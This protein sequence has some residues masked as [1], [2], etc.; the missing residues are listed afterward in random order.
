MIIDRRLKD[1]DGNLPQCHLVHH[2]S[3]TDLAHS[4]SRPIYWETGH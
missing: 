4:I 2:K 3:N 1:V